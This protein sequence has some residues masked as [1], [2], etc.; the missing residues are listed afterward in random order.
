[1]RAFAIGLALALAAWS[2]VANLVVGD[3]LYVV[4]NLVLAG[5]L[6]LLATH[7]GL[8]R[9]DLGLERGLILRGGLWGGAA[10]VLVAGVVGLGV[11]LA[12]EIETV[13]VLLGDQRAQLPIGEAL[14]NALVRIPLGTALFEEVAFRGVLLAALLR[15]YGTVPAVV[16][17]SVV[18]GLWHIA[19]T[20]IALQANGVDPASAAGVLAIAATVALTTVAGVVFAVLRLGSGSLL[21]PFLAHWATNAIGLMAAALS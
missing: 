5:G 8:T 7:R 6:V 13:G 2:L 14:F 12:D 3:S 10:V 11:L 4:R 1:M 21:A 20:M 15:R 19:P 16:W 18:F 9:R 17:S